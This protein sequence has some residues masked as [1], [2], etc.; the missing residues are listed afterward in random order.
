MLA[1]SDIASPLRWMLR[2]HPNTTVLLADAREVDTEQQVVLVDDEH[3]AIP[4][5]YLILAPGARHSYFGRD[6]WEELAP[7]LKSLED[8]REIRRRFLLAF[9]E[10]EKLDDPAERAPWLT[11]VIVGGGP[12][13]VELAGVLPDIARNSMRDDF[14]HFDPRETRVILLEGGPRVLPTFP[15]DLSDRAYR[16]LEKLH[17]EVRTNARV[18]RLEPGAVWV[19]DE[20]IP[21]RTVFWAAG[22]QA[23]PLG[24]TL[25]V[26]VERDGRVRVKPD[27]SVPGHENVFVVGDLAAVRQEDGSD[28]PG[29]AP[30]ANQMGKAAARN[31]VRLVHGETTNP[32][33]YRDKG[34]LATIGRNHAIVAVGRIHLAGFIAWLFWLILHIMYLAGFRNRLSVLGEWAYSYFTY[35]RGARLLPQH[36]WERAAAAAPRLSPPSPSVRA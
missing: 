8:A 24:R 31:V 14:R 2:K 9:E 5:D 28:V 21:T 12:T 29:V 1:P 20:C 11:F 33:R 3:R 36:A 4:Y 26:P 35:Q 7:G 13:G 18:T 16:D 34:T 27:L 23:S 6:D 30:A 10:A 25:G 17:V 22:N 32:F 15:D 19:G